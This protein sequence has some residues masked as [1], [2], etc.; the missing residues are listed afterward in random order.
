MTSPD[1]AQTITGVLATTVF[2][3]NLQQC[4]E[5]FRVFSFHKNGKD[6]IFLANKSTNG[7]DQIFL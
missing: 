1:P 6:H 7:G 5:C 4:G 2:K 3:R